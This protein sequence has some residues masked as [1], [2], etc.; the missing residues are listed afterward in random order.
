[1]YICVNKQRVYI[2]KRIYLAK[3]HLSYCLHSSDRI[4]YL[5][6]ITVVKLCS[7]FVAVEAVAIQTDKRNVLLNMQTTW[8]FL[9]GGRVSPEQRG[10]FGGREIIEFLTEMR[11]FVG[12]R[13]N[14]LRE[15]CHPLYD[16]VKGVTLTES[17]VRN[18]DPSLTYL[19]TI[20][21]VLH[22]HARVYYP[23]VCIGMVYGYS[24]P[25]D[26]GNICALLTGRQWD[27]TRHAIYNHSLLVLP[28]VSSSF[29]LSH[30]SLS[31][32]I[33]S[34]ISLCC[35]SRYTTFIL[36]VSNRRK[37]VYLMITNCK[38]IPLEIK[39]YVA[40]TRIDHYGVTARFILF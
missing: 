14:P 5:F 10:V 15:I 29:T 11:P 21:L 39:L 32:A 1:M 25:R 13:E 19:P 16:R 35:P 31:S 33:H 30:G 38:L 18:T 34:S 37:E 27:S 6:R 17:F 7:G 36:D 26:G 40:I 28:S 4:L 3:L 9:S 23:A 12:D 20:Y 24:H 2:Y 8:N 22:T